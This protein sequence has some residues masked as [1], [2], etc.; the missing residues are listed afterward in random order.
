MNVKDFLSKAMQLDS[1][2]KVQEAYDAYLETLI[3][4]FT[5]LAQ[6]GKLLLMNRTVLI[7]FKSFE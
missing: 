3:A 5:M 6:K 7:K 1:E 4:I 2:R